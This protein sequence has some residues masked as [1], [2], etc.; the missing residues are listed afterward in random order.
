MQ[1]SAQTPTTRTLFVTAED[2]NT[3]RDYEVRQL[4]NSHCIRYSMFNGS[5][6]IMLD[7]F[8]IF[9]VNCA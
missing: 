1:S 9:Y 3:T 4:P 6:S 2:A 7:H 5:C 8:T